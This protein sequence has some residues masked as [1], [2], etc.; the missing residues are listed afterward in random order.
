MFCIE[1][2]VVCAIEIQASK[3]NTMGIT[4]Y[5]KPDP[6]R[7]NRLDP[8]RTSTLGYKDDTRPLNAEPRYPMY[9][10]FNDSINAIA[11]R[12]V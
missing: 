4:I 7:L 5:A 6:K 3:T 11:Q 10:H 2:A 1:E 12:K 9:P 8:R